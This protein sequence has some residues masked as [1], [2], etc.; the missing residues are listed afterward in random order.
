MPVGHALKFDG[1]QQYFLH[2]CIH[3]REYKVHCLS[4]PCS[5]LIGVSLS[6]VLFSM[7]TAYVALPYFVFMRYIDNVP[8]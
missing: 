7:Q 6:T 8:S 3:I 4:Q 1:K 2:T 5:L